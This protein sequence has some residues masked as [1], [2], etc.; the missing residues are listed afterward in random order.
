MPTF[1]I[2]RPIFA[3]VVAIFIILGGLVSMFSLPV[4]Q[5]PEV[6]PPTINVSAV[7]PG[8]SAEVM[9]E[10][11][12]Q[13]ISRQMNGV[14]G[15]MYMSSSA[16]AN[17]S[18]SVT[19]TFEPDVDPDLAQVDVQNRLKNAEASL[20]SA[21][22]QQGVQVSK[23]GAN[24]LMVVGLASKTGETSDKDMGDYAARNIQPELQRINGVGNVQLFSSE[25]AMRIWIDPAKLQ[26]LNLSVA[27]VS[28]A[29]SGQNI[30]IPAGGIG[31][32]P[33]VP[34][35]EITAT[36]SVPGQLA[37]EAEFANIILR[38]DPSG[39]TVRLKDVARVEL[40]SQSYNFS[41]RL[42]G[43]PAVNLGIQLTSTG[44][45]LAVAEE[46]RAKMKSLEP[47]FPEDMT[48]KIPYDSSTFVGISIEKVVHT[49]FE[50][51]FLVFLVMLLFLQNL[52]Y[53]LIPTIVV[54][55]ALLGTFIAL[56]TLGMSIN[57]LAMF[58]M[59]L[60]I[61]IVVD[62]AI[63]VVENVERILAT[64]PELTP[65]EATTKAM[66]QI[67][68]AV[69]GITLVLISVFIPLAFFSGATGNIYR[70]FSIVMAVS[71]FFSAFLALSLTPALC[72]TFLKPIAEDHEKTTGFYGWFNRKFNSGSHKYTGMVKASLHRP[73]R[74]MFM[75][76]C[77]IGGA[78]FL[79]MRLP[80]GFL[81]TEDQG[82]LLVN[83]QLPSGATQERTLAAMEATEKYMLAQ[84]EVEN[85]VSILG[86][87]FSGQGQNAGLAFV[88]LKDWSERTG[89]GQS[90]TEIS[91]KAVA[92][93]SSYRD[94]FI[95]AVTP[96]PIPALGSSSGFE[97]RLQD[98]SGKGH[99][100]LL[101]ARNELLGMARQSPKLAGV[102]TEG[103]EDAPQLRIDINRETALAQGISFESI[104]QTLG[105]NLG[106]AY[107]NDFPNSGRMQQVIVQAEPDARM[108]PDDVLRLTVPNSQGKMVPLS[109]F[110]T[111]KW[112]TGPQQVNSYNGY[113][114]MSI[115]GGAAPGLSSGEA[116]LEMEALAKKLPSGFG[117][118]WTGQSLEEQKA[119]SSSTVLYI[120]AIM[121]VFL[122]LAALYES[123]SIP[124]SVILVVPLGILGVVIG[125]SMRGMENDIYFQV[126]M[127]TVVGLSAKNAI[128]II[129]FAKDLQASGKT[130]FE[131]ALLAA[132]LRFRPIIMTSLA[133]ILG[134]VP[135]YIASGAS[136]ASQRAVG[137]SVFWGMLIGTIISVFF[138]PV[139][140][141]VVRL[142]FKNTA[143]GNETNAM[144]DG[145]LVDDGPEDEHDT[146][147]GNGK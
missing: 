84:P 42:N 59:V 57:I 50:A 66:G 25:K 101:N 93:L 36:L 61:G 144:I 39:A 67:T 4:A 68:G 2:N 105:A 78:A 135:L 129:E 138:V 46:I 34:G 113:P 128:L 19:I 122:C 106:S 29:I 30:Q 83:V 98:R 145:M 114:S 62:D 109:T 69:V 32:A 26:G 107:I 6:A 40:A 17:G 45:A 13:V 103:L 79:F 22:T 74:I 136:S 127:I 85:M 82:Y 104:A 58:A 100:A 140:Y 130:A 73:W 95:F 89:K 92:T 41:S 70:Q 81:P 137:T 43:K 91:N 147:K 44:N 48:W 14:E 18:G 143:G 52:R 37:N 20:P 119:G 76:L 110:V 28:R 102:R 7:Y 142:M 10:T 125:T 90:A 96:A 86:F 11:V 8:A 5:Y 55:I 53:T 139:F 3:W 56:V 134:V 120:F 123:W 117:I 23:A 112:E 31:V 65:K 64:E 38:A 115:T 124:L 146:D 87:S 99:A 35:Q 108:Q 80:T 16:N 33:N 12:L 121:A 1:F 88:T 94:A 63:V 126:G 75:Y 60:V 72:A 131:A 51:I 27:D 71:I 24:F 47:F 116:I 111:A 141:L 77:I 133:F 97:L 118:E 15:M 9:D 21:V 49:L 132:R 54:P